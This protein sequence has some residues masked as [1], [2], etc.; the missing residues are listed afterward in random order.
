[1]QGPSTDDI[2]VT[3][4]AVT[5]P[6]ANAG[7]DQTVLVGNPVVLDATGSTGAATY[8][9]TQVSGTAV[10]LASAD[11]ARPTF[12]MPAGTTPLVFQVDVTGPGG[13]A[14]DQVS[15][16]ATPDALSITRSEYR[17]DSQEWRVEG[18]SS[19]L[20]NN[21]VTVYLGNGTTGTVIGIAQVDT[22]GAWS[23]RQRN[24]SVTPTGST[25]TIQSSR[26]GLLVGVGFEIH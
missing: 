24:S 2:V 26:G 18:T 25:V 13:T 7:P 11:T 5:A 15:V 22:T 12:T 17:P 16:T 4:E 10:T 14:S 1:P 21:I 3:V 6:V 19:I 20:D 9:W 8:A 23:V